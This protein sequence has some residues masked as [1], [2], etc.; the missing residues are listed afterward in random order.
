MS[1]PLAPRSARSP[2]VTVL[3]A[4]AAAT[5]VVAGLR[6]ASGLIGPVFLALT[7]T[8]SVYPLRGL[9]VRRGV[10]SWAAAL[11]C[12]VAV[13]VL[14]VG[15]SLA[16]VTATAQFAQLLPAYESEFDAVVS[17]L[18][19]WLASLGVG[20]DQVREIL[21]SVTF[22]RIT[23]LLATLL[24]AVVAVTSDLV[25]ILT[26]VLFL[27]VD[28]TRFPGHLSRVGES[29]AP[30]VQSLVGFAT[31]TRRY[32]Q[33][34]T[35]FG[36]IVAVLDSVAL[37]ALGIPV[38]LLWGLLAFI[39]NYIPNIG[40]VIGLVPPAIL[41]LLEGGPGLCLAVIGVYSVINVVIQTI[42]QPKFVGDAV[43]LSTTL[44]FLSLIFWT[45][46]LG[47][48]G[49]LLAIPLSLLTRAVL[50]DLDPASHWLGPLLSNRD[51]TV[52][53]VPPDP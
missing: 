27:G 51:P 50:V 3:I 20:E 8:I 36:L 37:A 45:W 4:L 26:L 16:L 25:F 48:M 30:L 40:F 42:I 10:P 32:L 52:T 53:S 44:T 5:I 34:S 23:G 22:G 12:V 19:G 47:P 28:G 21:G 49:A 29:R 33:I 31:G 38:P 18:G 39:T 11:C 15:L 2:G 6:S 43:G 35:I 24:G 46:V 17:D 13:Y 41:G 7:L 9:L 14:L 1:E